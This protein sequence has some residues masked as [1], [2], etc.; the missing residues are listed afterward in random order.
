M[1]TIIRKLKGTSKEARVGLTGEEYAH[2]QFIEHQRPN[3]SM[4]MDIQMMR[5]MNDLIAHFE[6][7]GQKALPQTQDER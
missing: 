4:P 7:P 3:L 2:L 1:I 6:T 5:E